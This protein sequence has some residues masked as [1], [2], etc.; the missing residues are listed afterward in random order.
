MR[1]PILRSHPRLPSRPGHWRGIHSRGAAHK[2]RSS[3][4][5]R[6]LV[7]RRGVEAA[8]R[9]PQPG[10]S[11]E[12]RGGH[13]GQAGPARRHHRRCRREHTRALTQAVKSI[14]ALCP[15]LELAH[16]A[17]PAAVWQPRTGREGRRPPQKC[18]R[19]WLASLGPQRRPRAAPRAATPK[20]P[21]SSTRFS[22]RGFLGRTG[23][24]EGV[25]GRT[26]RPGPVARAGVGSLTEACAATESR[27]GSLFLP[28]PNSGFSHCAPSQSYFAARGAGILSF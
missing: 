15:A 13:T 9:A 17:V 28:F 26:C 18:H 19:R 8:G 4:R 16:P 27:A 10:S 24:R 5:P 1:P 20:R 11:S 22:P 23:R 21:D 25:G 3:L 12:A 7:A 2:P 14:Q 6:A